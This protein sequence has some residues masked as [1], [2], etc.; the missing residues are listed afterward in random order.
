LQ[1]LYRKLGRKN[2]AATP[3]ATVARAQIGSVT[4]ALAA[5]ALSTLTLKLTVAQMR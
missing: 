2:A 3:R 5:I 1:R 4:V